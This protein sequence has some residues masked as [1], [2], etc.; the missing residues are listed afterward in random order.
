MNRDGPGPPLPYLLESHTMAIDDDDDRPR[1]PRSSRDDDDRP[2]RRRRDEDDDYEAPRKRGGMAPHHGVVILI[3]GLLTPCCGIAGIVGL[4]LG[5]IDLG[6]MN[7]GQ[8]DPSGKGL[9]M[10]GTIIAA[11][12]ILINCGGGIYINMHP[13]LL[14]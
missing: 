10:A 14:R 7:K 6:K 12:G 5:I 3:L 2:A 11:V 9:T 4:I 8:M 1:R 13:E